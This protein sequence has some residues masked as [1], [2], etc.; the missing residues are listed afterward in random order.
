VDA[1]K[2]H[3]GAEVFFSIAAFGRGTVCA[4]DTVTPGD[5]LVGEERAVI[6]VYY[7]AAEETLWQVGK[8]YHRS[9]RELA[10]ENGL[11]DGV[12]SPLQGVKK[13]IV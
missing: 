1:D 5:P 2:I 4:V 13:L 10:E 12:S 11:A 8:R 9:C 6:R 3:L 7:P